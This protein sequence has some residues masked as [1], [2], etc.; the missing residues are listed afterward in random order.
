MKKINLV[1]IV[2]DD[3]M[4]LYITKKYIE[5]SGIVKSVMVFTNGKKAYDALKVMISKNENLPQIIFLDLNMPIWD[6]WQFMDEFTQLDNN[7]KVPI[8]ILSSSNEEKDIEKAKHYSIISKYLVK[9]IKQG[10]MK[11]ILIELVNL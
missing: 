1:C 11:E 5:L 10:R 6:G 3:P 2:D 8:C 7:Q 4:H 9:P